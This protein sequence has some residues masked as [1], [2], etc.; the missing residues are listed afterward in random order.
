[1]EKALEEAKW[2]VKRGWAK[3]PLD[4]IDHIYEEVEV[5]A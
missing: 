4:L 2:A 3:D 1:M 5:E